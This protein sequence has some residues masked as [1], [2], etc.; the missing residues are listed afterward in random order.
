MNPLSRSQ[1]ARRAA[2]NK[3]KSLPSEQELGSEFSL[4]YVGHYLESQLVAGLLAQRFG[5]MGLVSPLE[6]RLPAKL[7]HAEVHGVLSSSACP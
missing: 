5:D 3:K 6:W 2:S 1:N 4:G 7:G